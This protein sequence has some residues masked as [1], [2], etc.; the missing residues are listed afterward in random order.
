MIGY[1]CVNANINVLNCYIYTAN[2]VCQ[3]CKKGY[4]NNNAGQCILPPN[5]LCQ[6]FN[7]LGSC[8]HCNSSLLRIVNGTCIDPKCSKGSVGNC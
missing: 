7:P 6:Q 8:L 2:G 4:I 3:V 1:G 5:K